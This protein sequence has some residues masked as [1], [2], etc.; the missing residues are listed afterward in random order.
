MGN[1]MAGYGAGY[2]PPGPLTRVA[3]ELMDIVGGINNGERDTSGA[4]G[5]SASSSYF[6]NQGYGEG[7]AD[8]NYPAGP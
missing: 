2:T 1:Y 4:W 7:L 3:K 6:I 5:D 8:A